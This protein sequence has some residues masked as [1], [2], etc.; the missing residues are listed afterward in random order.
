MDTPVDLISSG[1]NIACIL[2]CGGIWIGGKG[3]GLTWKLVQCVVKPRVSVS[4]TGK[5]HIQ[6]SDEDC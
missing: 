5:C 4:I 1:S 6:L 2:Q 3:W